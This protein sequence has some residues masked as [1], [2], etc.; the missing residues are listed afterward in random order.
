MEQ[1]TDV[2]NTN[3]KKEEAYESFV[4]YAVPLPQGVRQGNADDYSPLSVH[5]S[6]QRRDNSTIISHEHDRSR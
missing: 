2:A 4:R 6:S 5:S 3:W 1:R